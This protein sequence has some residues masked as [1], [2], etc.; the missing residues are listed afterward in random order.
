MLENSQDVRRKEINNLL[1]R[2]SKEQL[3][4]LIMHLWRKGHL[5]VYFIEDTARQILKHP[6]DC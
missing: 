3:K 5:H 1:E 4:K 2:L 6:E